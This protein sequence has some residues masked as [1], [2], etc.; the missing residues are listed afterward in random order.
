M[1]EQE[2]VW[3]TDRTMYNL[4][5]KQHLMRSKML[6]IIGKILN[7]I[8]AGLKFFFI[9]FTCVFVHLSALCHC[10]MMS[11]RVYNVYMY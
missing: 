2:S 4:N 8:L 5:A 7:S 3:I 6:A 11:F 9:G 1:M 10:T